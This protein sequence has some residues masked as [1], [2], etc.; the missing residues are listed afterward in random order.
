MKASDSF[1]TMLLFCKVDEGT[2]FD[3]QDLHA[4]DKPNPAGKDKVCE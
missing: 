2:S 1:L 3:S 4:V